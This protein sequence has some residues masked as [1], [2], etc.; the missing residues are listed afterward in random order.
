MTRPR[1]IRIAG[2]TGPGSSF[3]RRKGERGRLTAGQR[4]GVR[5]QEFSAPDIDGLV[6]RWPGDW[7]QWNLRNSALRCPKQ[8]LGV[9][10]RGLGFGRFRF[11]RGIRIKIGTTLR[12]LKEFPVALDKIQSAANRRWTPEIYLI[13]SRAERFPDIHANR[14]EAEVHQGVRERVVE[15]EKSSE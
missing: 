14:L 8:R 1:D 10:S 9:N 5:T 3:Q 4:G 6:G 13:S 15:C 11:A 12:I 7:K 2:H